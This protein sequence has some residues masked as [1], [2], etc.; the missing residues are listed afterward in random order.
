MKLLFY[1]LLNVLFLLGAM[2]SAAPVGNIGAPLLWGEGFLV[3]GGLYNVTA[4]ID[5][6]SQKNDLP[7]QQNRV[8]WATST[9]ANPEYRHYEQIRSSKN[10]Y[11]TS[12]MTLG[13][14][15]K[16]ANMI[17]L[18]AG[19]VNSKIDLTY[20][21]KTIDFGFTTKANFESD[22]DFYYGIGWSSIIHEGHFM[23]DTP[24]RFGLDT[25]YRKLEM[26]DD[27]LS[28]SGKFY[29]TSLDEFQFALVLSAEVGNIF[30]YLGCRI[31]SITG[32]EH[33]I[34]KNIGGAYYE[35][36]YIDYHRDIKWF[37]N[38]GYLAGASYYIK[39]LVIVNL[40]LRSG[41]EEG[42]GFS[43]TVKF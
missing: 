15:I 14:T 30:P 22:N 17:Y 19:V 13:A 4:S 38:T 26:E 18:M 29:S 42:I 32:S 21:D 34:D 43:T 40:E 36:G 33:F 5:F 23:E 6:D 3:S 20:Y 10:E 9:V 28:D 24:V 31:S 7:D 11:F 2:A 16:Q 27:D 1:V 8:I 35:N 37:K 12:G 41:S 39:E 25:K